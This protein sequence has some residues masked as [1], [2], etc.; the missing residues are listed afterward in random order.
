MRTTQIP[1]RMTRLRNRIALKIRKPNILQWQ[2]PKIQEI[3]RLASHPN[4]L[5]NPANSDIVATEVPPKKIK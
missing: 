1:I 4:K 5:E 2:Q 3:L